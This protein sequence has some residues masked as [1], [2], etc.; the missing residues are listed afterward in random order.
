M[1]MEKL[2]PCLFCGNEHPVI[3]ESY[4]IWHVECPVCQIRFCCDCT[5]GHD[6]DKVETIRRWNNRQN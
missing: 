4:G 5:A 2:K 6:R 1:A 3:R